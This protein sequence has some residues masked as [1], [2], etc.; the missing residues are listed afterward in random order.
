MNAT[1]QAILEGLR[2]GVTMAVDPNPTRL[3][4][5]SQEAQETD[6]T[7]EAWRSVG[8]TFQSVLSRPDSPYRGNSR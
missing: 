2:R 8:Q 6:F 1:A 4:E 5:L 7:W 3:R